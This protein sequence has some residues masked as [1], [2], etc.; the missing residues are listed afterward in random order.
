M[1][2]YTDSNLLIDELYGTNKSISPQIGKTYSLIY[3]SNE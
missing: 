1:F 2:K 3:T